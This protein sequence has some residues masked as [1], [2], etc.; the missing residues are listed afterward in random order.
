ME[1]LAIVLFVTKRVFLLS[2]VIVG[3]GFYV[4]DIV[5]FVLLCCVY[6]NL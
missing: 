2:F 1:V 4:K 5:L 6:N 3:F